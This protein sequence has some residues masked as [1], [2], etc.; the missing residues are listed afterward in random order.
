MSKEDTDSLFAETL[1]SLLAESGALLQGHFL[2][3]SGLHSER[4]FQ[5][6]LL[7]S[8]PVRAEQ[9]GRALA[10][11]QTDPPDLILSPA[12]GA[13]IIGHEVARALSVPALFT[14]RENGSMALRRG[15]ALKKGQRVVVVEDIVTTG[16]SSGEVVALARSYGAEVIGALAIVRRGSR[17]DLGTP[18]RS[19]LDMPIRTYTAKDCPL[20][21]EGKPLVKPGSRMPADTPATM[22]K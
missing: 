13:I 12:M 4:Y 6:A 14:E 5:C 21:R 9:V 11:L 10:A 19:L 18:L 8:D 15:F 1:K 20:C 7:L 22:K 16:V 2:L 3:S 17:A